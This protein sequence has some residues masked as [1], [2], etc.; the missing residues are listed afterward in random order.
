MA[1]VGGLKFGGA[2][3]DVDV[4]VVVAV[5]LGELEVEKFA[6]AFVDQVAAG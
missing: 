3:L 4:A 2:D 6:V 1:Y 5:G